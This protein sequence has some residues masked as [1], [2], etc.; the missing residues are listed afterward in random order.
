MNS[1]KRIPKLFR[2]PI[3]PKKF[4]HHIARRIHVPRELDFLNS[5][6]TQDGQGNDLLDT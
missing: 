3:P 2:K 4:N 1:K 5:K 6:L